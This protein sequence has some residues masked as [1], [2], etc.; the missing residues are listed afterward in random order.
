MIIFKESSRI[1]SH[2]QSLKKDGKRIG[3]V[4]TMGA[5]HPGHLSLINTCKSEN[6]ITVCSIFVN[7]TQF[8]NQEDY[9][10]YPV[11][12][13]NDVKL[14]IESG[15]DILFLPPAS[16]VYPKDYQKKHYDLGNIENILE[17]FYRPGHFQGVCQVVDRLLT[18]VDPQALYMGRKDY[19]QCMVI[20]K[21]LEL[22]KRQS[23]QLRICPTQ[24][25]TDGLAMSSRNLRLN[26]EE[27]KQALNISKVLNFM[28]KEIEH[29]PIPQIKEIAVKELEKDGFVVDYIEISDAQ[30]LE[31]ASSNSKPL[32]GLIAASLNKVRLIDNMAL[33]S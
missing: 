23:L 30:T 21:L 29:L 32:V 31:P 18:I 3:F 12:I 13:E 28:K 22:T 5:L 33:N 8:N 16:Q 27:R 14:L 25:E 15:C 10:N 26:K 24:R 20:Q 19:Q 1:N 2:L 9:I 4:P 11:T 17:G 6:D 7:P